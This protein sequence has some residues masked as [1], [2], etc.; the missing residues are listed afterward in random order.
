MGTSFGKLLM[1]RLIDLTEE[2]LVL[3]QGL[4]DRWYNELL[5]SVEAMSQD[6]PR[7]M[8]K[9]MFSEW[10]DAMTLVEDL[11]GKLGDN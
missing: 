9:K 1:E 4:T 11:K 8:R 6:V 3:I 10:E 5:A 7:H 2:E